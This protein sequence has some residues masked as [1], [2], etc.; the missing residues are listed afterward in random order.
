MDKWI[1]AQQLILNKNSQPLEIVSYHQPINIHES[2]YQFRVKLKQE[3][4]PEF[5]NIEK[6]I[7]EEPF[8]LNERI[9]LDGSLFLRLKDISDVL[10]RVIQKDFTTILER[11]NQIACVLKITPFSISNKIRHY[12]KLNFKQKVI[13]LIK[14]LMC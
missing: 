10:D 6:T 7:S 8:N 14:D 9:N 4:N 1:E 12:Y 13:F 3:E 2:L 5:K 11:N